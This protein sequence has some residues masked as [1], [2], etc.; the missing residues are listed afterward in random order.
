MLSRRLAIAISVN[1][2]IWPGYAMDIAK[3]YSSVWKR[4][5][6]ERQIVCQVAGDFMESHTILMAKLGSALAK[7]FHQLKNNLLNSQ[8][9]FKVLS[10][11]VIICQNA[12]SAAKL[13][14][15]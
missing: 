1:G 15:S 14:D 9:Y 13:S 3:N 8:G 7:I 10:K 12:S 5:S 4:S 11:N 6:L 2:Q